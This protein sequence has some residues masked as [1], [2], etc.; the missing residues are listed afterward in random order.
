MFSC[1]VILSQY[2]AVTIFKVA[3]KGTEQLSEHL[4]ARHRG[5]MPTTSPSSF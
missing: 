2:F 3:G 5:S 1:S 4:Y